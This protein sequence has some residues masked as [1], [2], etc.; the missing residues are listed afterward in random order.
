MLPTIWSEMKWARATQRV[1]RSTYDGRKSRLDFDIF[2]SQ[3]LFASAL[4]VTAPQR[5]CHPGDAFIRVSGSAKCPL[6]WQHSAKV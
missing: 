2:S 4:F 6:K 1:N 3:S 5:G